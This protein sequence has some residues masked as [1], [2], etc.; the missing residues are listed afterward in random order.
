MGV[1]CHTN[2]NLANKDLFIIFHVIYLKILH[3]KMEKK[4]GLIMF[5]MVRKF[6]I[7]TTYPWILEKIKK[8]IIIPIKNVRVIFEKYCQN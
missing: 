7:V 6:Y 5:L 8:T 2:E 4:L 1:S 3:Q